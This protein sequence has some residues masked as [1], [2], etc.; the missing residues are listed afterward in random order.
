MFLKDA[1]AAVLSL[2]LAG[3]AEGLASY[4][5][6]RRSDLDLKWLEQQENV[7]AC[8]DNQTD[9]GHGFRDRLYTKVPLYVE[10]DV[11]FDCSRLRQP[12]PESDHTRLV[13][14]QKIYFIGVDPQTLG[15]AQAGQWMM[16][17]RGVQICAQG[18]KL[19]ETTPQPDL[20]SRWLETVQR[21]RELHPH[22][23]EV[24]VLVHDCGG[25]HLFF[26]I[27]KKVPPGVNACG[28]AEILPC[29]SPAGGS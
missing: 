24:S 3:C 17:N 10:E 19:F 7:S 22:E 13:I 9:L 26:V 2:S 4:E 20:L 25:D 6:G 8:R 14:A 28:T 15:L 1:I 23:S 18:F 12:P 29:G 11:Q 27:P 5:S 21:A 16:L